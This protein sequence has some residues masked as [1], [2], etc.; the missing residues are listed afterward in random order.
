MNGVHGDTSR[1]YNFSSGPAALPLPVLQQAQRELIAFPGA[2]A[3][4]MEISHRGD[5]FLA[6]L[7]S[8]RAGI[9]RLLAIPDNYQVLFLQGGSRL[10]FGMIPMNF[11]VSG[12]HAEFVVTGSWSSKAEVEAA[13]L[14]DARTCWTGESEGFRRLPDPG[15]IQI[16]ESA[17]Y[18][19]FTSNETIQGV[20]FDRLPD[21]SGIPWIC[22]ASSDFLSRPVDFTGLGMVFA[23]AQ[24]NA[25]PAGLTVI[26]IRDD[27]LERDKPRL[28][29]YLD[30]ASHAEHGSLYNT[31]PT[32]AIYILDLV[33]KWIDQQM[34][35]LAALEKT[36]SAKATKLYAVLDQSDG[37]Y[38]GHAA[39]RARSRMNVTFRL[40][41]ED[42][43]A[44]FVEE[45][46]KEGL[47][48]L[49]GH[50]SVGGIRASIYNAMPIEGVEALSEFMIRFQYQNWK[51]S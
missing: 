23:C 16:D 43:E 29:G 17:S 42:L 22:D 20:Q 38:N 37:F 9:R 25:G 40:P 30:Y 1:V 18:G 11:L 4:V 21:A 15:S 49:A 12:G 26:V 27:L 19:Y 28:P 31:P 45:A 44:Q 6:I 48:S 7:E 8:A 3:S 24:K 41:S 10:Q 2:G 32:F 35:G 46:A 14:G 34:G 33:C 36:N 50:R 13:I 51:R 39:A 5:T 47:V